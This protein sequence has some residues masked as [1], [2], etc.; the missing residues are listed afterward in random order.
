[1]LAETALAV[2]TPPRRISRPTVLTDQVNL[3]AADIIFERLLEGVSEILHP[4]MGNLA[5]I[6]AALLRL[7]IVSRHLPKRT[8]E[9]GH[10]MLH[11]K[12]DVG[13]LIER[14]IAGRLPI[15]RV[16]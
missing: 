9:H 8:I 10:I 3:G 5:R 1:M 4:V 7:E 2:F 14:T 15:C 12:P 13:I 6:G 11:A 16:E